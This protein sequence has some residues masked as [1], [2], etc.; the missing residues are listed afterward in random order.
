[1]K[2]TKCQACGFVGWSDSGNCKNCGAALIQHSPT[3]SQ[4]S[5]SHGAGYYRGP[6]SQEGGK[7][8]LAI[9]SLVLGILSFLTFGLLGVGAITGIIVAIVAM[10]KI[11]REPWRYG[12]HGL[13]VA[14]LVL[15]IT[16]LVTVV[17]VGIIAAIAIPNLLASR[18][19]ANEAS[20]LQTLRMVSSAESTYQSV[21]QK[22]GTLEELVSEGLI[23]PSLGDG[24]KHGY[25][26]TLELTKNEDNLEGFEIVAVPLTYKSSGRR[27]FFVDESLVIRA[28]DNQGG[29]S[30]V[31]DN[32]LG[33]D[34]D[35]PRRTAYRSE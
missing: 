21:F 4:M 22:F 14:G 13:A 6:Q 34:Y 2:S 25:K 5:S 32:P 23:D 9:F 10:G 24:E 3:I 11:R 7:K 16:S 33:S 30:T 12:G 17:P 29:P 20:A 26:F 18:L 1:M 28:A 8:G 31:A 35:Y 19:A 27:S 15:N